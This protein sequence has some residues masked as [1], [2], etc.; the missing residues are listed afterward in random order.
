MSF[1][2]PTRTRVGLL[3]LS[4]NESWSL[5]D[6]VDCEGTTVACEFNSS[7]HRRH[8]ESLRPQD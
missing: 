6:L 1:M 5:S 8:R 3:G 7:F 4:S 2:A